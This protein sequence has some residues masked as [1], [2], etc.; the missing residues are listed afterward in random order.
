MG[1]ET[2]PPDDEGETE[3]NDYLYVCVDCSVVSY[4]QMEECPAC[5]SSAEKL[6]LAV[7][8]EEGRQ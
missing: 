6:T 2:Q 3:T 7:V 5:G 4:H 8:N 1:S